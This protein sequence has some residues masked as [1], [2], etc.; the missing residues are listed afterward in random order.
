M[1]ATALDKPVAQLWAEWGLSLKLSDIPTEVLE[2]VKLHLLDQIGCQISCRS[3]PTPK[4]TQDYVMQFGLPGAASVLGTSITR[5]P[6]YAAFANAVAGSS[7]E[8]DDYGGNGAYAHPGCVVVP[9][10][11]AEG[12][13]LKTSGKDALLATAAGFEVVMR[14]AV[15]S[16]PSMLVGRGVHQTGPHGVFAVALA[17]AMLN[18]DDVATTVNALSIAGSHA[19]GTTEYSQGG[20]EVKRV[21]AG[22]GVAGGIRAGRLARLGITAP[23]TIVEGRRGVLQALCNEFDMAPLHEDLGSRWHFAEKAALKA[24]ASCALVHHHFAAYDQILA[25]YDFA[26]EDIEQIILGCEPLTLVHN[27]AAGPYPDTLVGAQFSAEFGMALRVVKG[28]NDVGTYLDLQEIGFKD[29]AI[30]AIAERVSIVGADDCAKPIPKGR[31][32]IHLRGGRVIVEDGY[33]LGS[34]ENPLTRADIEAKYLGLVAREVGEELA[35]RSLDMI[36][37]LENVADIGEL[38][39]LFLPA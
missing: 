29:A 25:K 23:A 16:M 32:T 37:D 39:R 11:L 35:Q 17:S 12:E 6:E 4:I 33:A 22:I 27:G 9:A 19:A 28:S 1:A 10:V 18:G 21:H 15:S 2:R 36:M 38:T 24:Y 5:D 34:P 14:L 20:G 8:I 31:V 3:M 7:F 26:I 13:V 30:S